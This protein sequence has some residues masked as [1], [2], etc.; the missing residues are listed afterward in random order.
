I[1]INEWVNENMEQLSVFEAMELIRIN[2]SAISTQFQ[3]WLTI[4]FSTIVAVFAGRGLLTGAIKWLVSLLYSLSSLAI[5]ATSIYL[6]ESNAQLHAILLERGTNIA[7]PVFA[8][9]VYFVLFI[10]GIATTLYFIHRDIN[11]L[12]EPSKAESA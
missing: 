6:A 12:S 2:E 9:I 11:S 3:M 5:A 7:L 10:S 4:T 1:P 8:G